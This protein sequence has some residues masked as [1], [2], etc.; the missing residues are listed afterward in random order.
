MRGHTVNDSSK[1]NEE[2]IKEI[3]VLKPRIQE[4]EQSV[5]DHKKVEETLRESEA[6]YRLAFESTSDG[7]FTIDRNFNI[8]S[9]TPNVER[10]LGYKVEEVINR[11]I[12]DL[13][14][15]TSESLTR[16][17]A[18]VVQVLSGVEVTCAVYEF[19]AKN[20]T[21]KIGEVTGTPIIREGKIL[22]VTAVVRDISERK[23]IEE[24]FAESEKKYRL[25][26]EKMTDIVWIQDMNLRTVYVSPS[27]KTMLGFTPEE[28][29][30]QDVH[31]QLTPESMSIA[32]DVMAKELALEQ[33]AQ[34]D[35]ERKIIIELEYY[36][37]DGSTRWIENIISGI[38]DNQGVLTGLHGVSRDITK[39]RHLEQELRESEQ[40]Y[41]ELVDFMPISLYEMD[42]QGNII[43]GNPEIFK[44]FGYV[45]DDLK[46]GLNAFQLISPQDLDRAL[47]TELMVLSGKR[48]GGTEYTGVRKDG[49]TFPFLNIASRII[50]K[51]EPVGLR[52]AIID[53]TQQKN[54]EKELQNA[55]EQLIQVEK[56]AS[57]G[58]LSAG[59]AHEILNPLNI[60][61]LGLQFLQTREDLPL[62]VIEDIKISMTHVNR[63]VTIAESLNQFSR[64]SGKEMVMADINDVIANV[65]TLYSTQLTIDGIEIETHYQTDLP[66]I[67][68]DKEKMEQVLINLISNAT[69]AMEGKEKKVLRITTSRNALTG[70]HDPLVIVVSD[71]GAGIKK[72]DMPKI[73][74]PFFTTR[75]GKGTGL[76]LSISYGI[77]TDHG[78]KIWAENSKQGGASFMIELPVRT[79]AKNGSL[80]GD[81]GQEPRER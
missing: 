27:I 29:L 64:I 57:I 58:R 46:K 17:V 67:F 41:R 54:T 22:G 40:K 60:I 71:T 2:L 13:N 39:R 9:I 10:Q 61:S 16:A 68:M 20:G 74:D 70:D 47:E 31:E 81:K 8:S 24:A 14:I 56:L 15:L 11:P 32:L 72:E 75:Q 38:R 44:T 73:F 12:Q 51:G 1:I 77:V 7:I 34:A 42:V 35:P 48:T 5:L 65:L 33:Q 45:Q 19:V 50:H 49:S 59:V 79:V 23:R 76:G 28:R 21:K 53:L 63:I 36:H 37:K 52:G 78:G 4:L 30:A 62:D 26:T 25:I 6:K 55:R 80:K 43:S 66:E 3:S 69:A 18:D